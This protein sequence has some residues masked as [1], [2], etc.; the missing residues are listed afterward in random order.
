MDVYECV[1][2]LR[3]VRQFKTD[4]VPDEVVAKIVRAGRWAPSS[5]NQQPWHFVT[6]TD[7]QVLRAIGGI[8]T[9]GRFLADAPLAIAVV[10]EN[11]DRADLDAG[12]ALQ[13]MEL[14]AWAEGLGTCFVGLSVPDQSGRIKE[15]LD[16]PRK[17]GTHNG[18]ALR[19]PSG[20]R[21]GRRQASQ[22]PVADGPQRALWPQLAPQRSD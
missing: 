16:I 7:P 3:T 10:M 12:R 8:A 22:A 1:R 17:P 21:Q 20:Q 4:A 19:L 14:V 5:R 6:I 15:I 2:A 9:S 13:Q 18:V 11:S